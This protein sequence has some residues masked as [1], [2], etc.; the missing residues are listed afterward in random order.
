VRGITA[1]SAARTSAGKSS[2][3]AAA[4]RF[5]WITPVTAAITVATLLALGLRIYILS[6]P[7]YLL[8]VTEYDDGPYFG[9]AVRLVDGV[10]PYR[11][12]V[13]VQPSGITLLMTPAALIAKVIGTAGGM[14]IGRILTV[15]A[16]TAAVVLGGLL[17]RHRGLLAVIVCCGIIAVYPDSVLTARTVLVEPWLVLFCL[18]GLLAV[19]DG[20]RPTSS[21]RRLL[22]GGVLFGFAGAVEAWAIVPVLVVI[23]VLLV[24]RLFKRAALYAGGV[25]A[26]FL[27]PVVPFAA[28]APRGFYD[29]LVTA[30]IGPRKDVARAPLQ[31]RLQQM[32]GLFTTH[33]ASH[34]LVEGVVIAIICLVVGSMVC[35]SLLTRRPP[36]A[37]EWF[38]VVT[39][40]LVVVMFLWPPQ[41]HYHFPTFLAPFLALAVA[42]PLSRLVTAVRQAGESHGNGALLRWGEAAV[43][44]LAV[45]VLAVFSVYTARAVGHLKAKSYQEVVA[46]RK[47]I[48]PGSCLFTD[49]VAFA[50]MANRFVSNVPDCSVMNDGLGTDLALSHGLSPATGAANV[51]AVQAVWWDG[52]RK[53]EFVWLSRYNG[54]RIAWTPRLRSYL[55][56]HFALV[57][58][59]GQQGRLYERKSLV[60]KS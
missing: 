24:S 27:V 28:L 2:G 49:S 4:R 19:F 38:G 1:R 56:N 55:N 8:G 58:S 33:G 53:A 13:L 46:A 23:G 37:L 50:I 36:P 20:D 59:Y 14:V 47:L 11:H 22:W 45:I 29:S 9:S 34:A 39:T 25:A 7:G 6:R 48:P 12:F 35:A 16:S 21:R 26:G 43:A 40:V 3:D 57:L 41:F 30:Q 54:R 52:F 17:V 32:T 44:G 18:A 15:L 10:L 31:M 42:L 5:P 51:P 60:H